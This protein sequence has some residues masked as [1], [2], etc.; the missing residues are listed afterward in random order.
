[1]EFSG[2]VLVFD[3]DSY[4]VLTLS[5]RIDRAGVL[6]EVRQSLQAIFLCDGDGDYDRFLPA[7]INFRVSE[8]DTVSMGRWTKGVS[9]PMA[10]PRTGADHG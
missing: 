1:M 3:L 5:K 4:S 8:R 10:P 2:R 6:G 9:F 7:H